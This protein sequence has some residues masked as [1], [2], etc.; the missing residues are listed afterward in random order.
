MSR[1]ALGGLCCWSVLLAGVA[2]AQQPVGCTSNKQWRIERLGEAHWR[3]IGDVEIECGAMKFFAEQIDVLT[4]QNQFIASGNVVFTHGGSR[5]AAERVEFNTKTRLGTFFIAS[6]TATL[7]SRG[8]DR[9]MFGTQEP[10]VFFYGKTIEKVG[11]DKYKITEGGFT[12]CVQPTP[13][14]DIVSGSVTLNLDDYVLLRNSLMRVKGVPVMYMPIFYYPMEEDDRSTGFLIPT[15]GVSTQRGQ[16][17]SNAFFWAIDRSQDATFFH[18]W[19]SKTG[20]G[21]GGEY[22]YIA[23][24]GSEGNARTY[25]LNEHPVVTPATGGN[26]AQTTPGRRSYQ[27]VAGA[28]Q[29][30]GSHVRARGRADYFSNITVQQAYNTDIYRASQRSRTYGGN[31]TGTWGAYNVSG[32]FERNETFFGETN[33]TLH[34]GAPRITFSRAERPLPGVPVYVTLGG[35]YVSLLRQSIEGTRVSDRGLMR[36][37]TSPTVRVPFTRWPFLTVNSSATAFYTRWTQS[38]DPVSEAQIP[39]PVTRRYMSFQSQ[40]TGPVFNR[41]FNRPASGFAERYKHLIE[42]HVTIQRTTL[43]TNFNRIVQLE[44]DDSSVGGT[45]RIAYGVSNRVLAKLKSDGNIREIL[46]VGVTQSYYTDARA[47]QVDREFRTSFSGTPPTH[48]S[49]VA[50][51]ARF[52]PSDRVNAN[53]S[54]E[55]D[56]TFWAI[57]TWGASGTLRVSDYLQTQA[58]WSQRRFIEKLSGF[59]DRGQLDHYLNQG[60]TLRS[61]GNQVGGIYSFH[62]DLMRNRFLQQQIIG[63][64]NAQCCGFSVEFQR[65]NAGSV[66][67]RRF[68]FAFTLA[69]IG[70]FSNFFGALGGAMGRR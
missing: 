22:R 50:V 46:N 18:D 20:Q 23:G 4:D 21:M 43:I 44:G 48:F 63:Y 35:E 8:G 51:G 40:I 11:P 16:S 1:L 66:Q 41:I 30:F 59:N 55:I 58:G 52:T 56:P 65:F 67:D 10:D 57:R 61:R 14:W 7:G 36:F 9:S 45:T 26:P 49:P 28:N 47:A 54:M 33:S 6:G 39:E 15:Y 29:V 64:Y 13:R 60:T 53:F 25:F 2:E 27:I 70:S 42:P 31:A 3:L 19:F 62:W 24:Q 34:G 32:T 37:H 12:T 69:G 68:N 38:R 5:I 17:I